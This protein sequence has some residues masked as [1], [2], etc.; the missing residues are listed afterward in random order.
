ADVH[1]SRFAF[2]GPAVWLLRTFEARPGRR[3]IA[4]ITGDRNSGGF[5]VNG[6]AVE[7]FSRHR[8]GGLIK[9]DISG[10]L[11]PGANLLA[12]NIQGYAGAPW[13]AT[14]ASYDPARPLPA[15]WGFRAGV[16]PEEQGAARG[17]QGAGMA[18]Y[19]GSF[20]SSDLGPQAASL[21]LRVG[22]LA[23][24][25]IWLNG[26]NLA[27]FWQIGPQEDYKLP[28]SWLSEQNELL[29]FAEEGSAE[30]VTLIA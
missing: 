14:L 12:L 27:R 1:L 20:A 22:R 9:A 8:S 13:R 21:R 18:F 28:V 16:T 23:K 5:F 10:L 26:R 29:I 6:Q 4:H 30:Q 24:G 15:R 25:Q 17:A 7:R 2:E 3:Y 19:R 11:R